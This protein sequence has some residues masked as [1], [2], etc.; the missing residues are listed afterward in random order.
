M[1]DLY[2]MFETDSSLEREGFWYKVS[3]NTGFLLARAGGHNTRFVKALEVKTRPYRRQIENGTLDGELGNELL[4]DAFAETVILDW[5][6]VSDRNGKAV[7]FSP[8]AAAALLKEL[9]DLFADLQEA[10]S[11]SANFRK[12]GIEEDAGNS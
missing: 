6:G 9:P 2:K 1:T 10:A 12:G 8:K 7:K 4:R 11:K 3:E 5:T